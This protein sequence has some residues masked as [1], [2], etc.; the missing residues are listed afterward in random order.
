MSAQQPHH[1]LAIFASGNGSNAEA[2]I[3]YFQN[4][5]NIKVAL[6]VSNNPNAGVNDVAHRYHIPLQII[7]NESLQHPDI[8]LEQLKK[9]NI[10]WIVLAGFLKKIPDAIIREYPNRIINIHPALLPKFGGKGMY[11]NRV[12][13]AVLKNKETETGI[14][15]HIVNEHYDEGPVIFQQKVPV[16]V[17]DTVETL[18]NRVRMLE[19][20]FFPRVIQQFICNT[21][22]KG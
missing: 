14:T 13:E 22:V 12:H 19:H 20:Q 21:P 4:D 15:I 16:D 3:R 8:I 9:F 1:H 5:Q 10:N 11:G 6:I 18:S 7:S 2:I 17:N